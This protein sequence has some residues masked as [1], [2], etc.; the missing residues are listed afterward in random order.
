MSEA[1]APRARPLRDQAS[2]PSRR[3]C[4]CP[5]RQRSSPRRAARFRSA[6]RAATTWRPTCGFLAGLAG[7]A[8]RASRPAAGAGAA[9]RPRRSPARRGTPCRR[10]T[11][12]ASPPAPA[13]GRP[14]DR[15]LA[16][17][18]RHR[19]AGAGPA[20]RSTGSPPPDDATRDG[21]GRERRWPTPIPFEAIAEHALVAAALQVHFARM[22]A[23][24]DAAAL[25]PVGDGA[26]PA[27]G[28]PPVASLVVGWARLRAAPATAPAR[29]AARSGTTS[30]PSARSAAR[31]QTIS[32]PRGRGRRRHGQ[33][34][35]LRRLP[36]LRQGALPAEGPG[37]RP[38][39]RRRRDA[40]A[41]TCWSASR[42]SAAARS[43][44]S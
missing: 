20:L 37:P 9:R 2:S 43:T 30:A 8:G 44:R 34:R 22:A 40:S 10:S 13:F 7:R 42:A 39:R 15:L 27:C 38:G 26:C 41:S 29:S 19:H 32:L 12:P 4:G 18:P 36:R 35:V 17:S 33:G 14:L 16:A 5:T 21:D 31:P 25:T 28:G 11:G 24:L 23:A 6:G 1:G 3:S